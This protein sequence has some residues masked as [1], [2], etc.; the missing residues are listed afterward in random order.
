MVGEAGE[1]G[2]CSAMTS[3]PAG[4][5]LEGL[6]PLLRDVGDYSRVLLP[7][8]RLR[9]YQIGPAR[10]IAESITQRLGRQFAV[11]FSRQAGKDE[12]LAQ[13]IAWLL[14]RYQVA[15]GLSSSP[16]PHAPRKPTSPATGSWID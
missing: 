11:V 3:A 14:T 8:Y 2:S 10:A 4:R 7:G 9:E 1:K 15:G 5:L 12:T 13:L 16:R 6:R